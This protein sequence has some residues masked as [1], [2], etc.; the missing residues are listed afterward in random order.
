MKRSKNLANQVKSEYFLEFSNRWIRLMWCI[1]LQ[2]KAFYERLLS[3]LSAWLKLISILMNSE[4]QPHTDHSGPFSVDANKSESLPGW[5]CLQSLNYDISGLPMWWNE[6][7]HSAW[8]SKITLILLDVP[9]FK[10]LNGSLK[11][12]NTF[13]LWRQVLI[14]VFFNLKSTYFRCVYVFPS[15]VLSLFSSRDLHYPGDWGLLWIIKLPPC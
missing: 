7:R 2:G 4:R 12:E 15:L 8:I 11:R 5:L 14:N 3:D 9:C 13:H 6:H 10:H 1:Y